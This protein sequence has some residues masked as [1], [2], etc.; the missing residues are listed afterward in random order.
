MND[1]RQIEIN[2]SSLEV[3]R[4]QEMFDFTPSPFSKNML[5]MWETQA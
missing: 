1:Y 4:N 3:D 2:T 5:A